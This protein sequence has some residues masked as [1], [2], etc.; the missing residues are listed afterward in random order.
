M[1]I[2]MVAQERNLKMESELEILSQKVVEDKEDL[3]EVTDNNVE[4]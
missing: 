4:E 1:I 2:G 3:I